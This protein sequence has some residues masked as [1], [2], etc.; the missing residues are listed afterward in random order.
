MKLEHSHTAPHD[1]D[2]E[3]GQWVEIASDHSPH[4]SPLHEYNGFGFMSSTH[5]PLDS[6]YTRPIHTSYAANPPLHPLIMP[7][8]PSQIT[9][10][11]E[12]PPA[13]IPLPRALAPVSAINT[14]HSAPPAP[15]APAPSTARKTLTDQDRRRMCQYHEDHPTIKQTEIGALFGV[16]RSTVSKVLR[17]KEK[18]LYPED[19][20][21]SP[22]KRS[23]GKFPDIERALSNWARNH[24][25]QGL[26]LS[27]DIIRD[28]AM[29]FATTVGSSECHAKVNS[30]IWLEKFKQKNQLLGAKARKNSDANESDSGL[31][32]DSKSGSETPNGISPIS[33]DSM[34]PG[35]PCQGQE[36]MKNSSPDSY[37]DFT[38]GYRHAHSQSAT[39]LITSY[40][41]NTIVSNFSGDLRSPNS[42]FFSPAS[43]CGPSPCMPSQQARLPVLASASASSLRPRRGTFPAISSEPTY[44]TTPASSEPS[45]PKYLQQSMATPALESPIEE[46]EEPSLSIDSAMHH[47]SHHGTS[48]NTPNLNNSPV[49]MAPPPNPSMSIS[50]SPRMGPS[51]GVSSP[52]SPPSQDEA[53]RALEVLMSFFQHQPS[54]VDP[55]EYITMGKMMEK[56]KLQGNGLPGG[57]HSMTVGERGEGGLPINRKRSIHSL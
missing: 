29:F 50:P 15:S 42:P 25:R 14:P 48:T 38:T 52:T 3:T 18:Y 43:S 34:L 16:E 47:N 32:T 35:S 2:F 28:K 33:P 39:S 19:G 11:S 49:S 24:Q 40:S 54:G 31:H 41:D 7:Q 57:M 8:W 6:I 22:I 46:L 4:Q 9:N 13:A 30:P 45:T 53:R 10:P 51:S 20:S 56:L 26:P 55:Q 5:V 1:E 23:K 44:M 37:L 17:Q 36:S 21:R 12:G 27:D